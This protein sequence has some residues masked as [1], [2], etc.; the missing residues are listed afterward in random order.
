MNQSWNVPFGRYFH[1]HSTI[2]VYEEVGF[3]IRPY[4]KE[5]EYIE[6]TIKSQKIHLFIVH[7]ISED[8]SFE[9]QTRKEIGDI[10]WFPLESLPCWGS[11]KK[12]GDSKNKF[13]MVTS[14]ISSLKKWLN[15][16][17]KLKG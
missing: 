12:T 8:T 16:Y 10:Q 14:F 17:H 6:R 2:Q 15:R 11:K 13:Y 1:D 9:T 4:V 3:D 5:N 7:G